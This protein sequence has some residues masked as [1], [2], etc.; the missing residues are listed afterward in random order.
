MQRLDKF[1]SNLWYWSRKQIKKLLKDE[2]VLVNWELALDWQIKI[3]FWDIISVWEE[4]IE[5]KKNL[6]LILNKPA[7][8]VTSNK[9]EASYAS[10]LELLVDYPYAN[11]VNPVWRLDADSTWLLFLTNNG[12]LTHNLISPKKNLFKKYL[13]TLE[14][15]LSEKDEEKIKSWVTINKDTPKKY[16]TKPALLEKIED[17]KYYISISEG[18]FHQV[19]KMFE[20]INNKVL[21]LHRVAIWGLEL[22]DLK[23]WEFQE[24]SSEQINEIFNK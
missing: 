3:N 10:Y 8:Y 4:N 5:Y 12:D 14:N 22:W 16:L 6:Y 21:T 15:N 13:I 24:L 17:K 9:P 20:A 19:K 2:Y 23:S 7:W 11:L 1:I 18:K